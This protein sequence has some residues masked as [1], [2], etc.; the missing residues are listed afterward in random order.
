MYQLHKGKGHELKVA[1]PEV[2]SGTTNTTPFTV[3]TAAGTIG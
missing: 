1:I 3:Q 2:G